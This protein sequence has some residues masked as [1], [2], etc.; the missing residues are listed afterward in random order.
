[1]KKNLFFKTAYVVVIVSLSLCLAYIAL[2]ETIPGLIPLIKKGNFEDIQNYLDECGTFKGILCTVLL[3]M[4]QV[5]SLFISAIP[6]QIAAGCVYGLPT[7][8]AICH[9]SSTAALVI[10]LTVWRRSGSR[11]EKWIPVDLNKNHRFNDFLSSQ[12]PPAYIIILTCLIP[13]I[14]NGLIALLASKMEISTK[15]FAF[16]VWFGNIV[17]VAVGCAVGNRIIQGDWSVAAVLFLFMIIL[18]LLMWFFRG[19]I[20]KVYSKISHAF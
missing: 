6:I 19:T 11:L 16:S 1:M 18:L 7:A 12:A 2:E 17:N 5:W 13:V 4:F 3:S 8:F 9:L 10:A 15:S 20:L 14:P